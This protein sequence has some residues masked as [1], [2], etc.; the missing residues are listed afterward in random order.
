MLSVCV[1]LSILSVYTKIIPKL[2]T[3]S[4]LKIDRKPS[5]PVLTASASKKIIEAKYDQRK[6]GLFRAMNF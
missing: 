6:E 3:T 5:N 4:L 1:E 2:S